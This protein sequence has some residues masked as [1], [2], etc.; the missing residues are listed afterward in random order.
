MKQNVQNSH[1]KTAFLLIFIILFL[2]SF[3]L[4]R[5]SSTIP[6]SNIGTK[7]WFPLPQ[8]KQRPTQTYKNIHD[9]IQKTRKEEI[10]A[11]CRATGVPKPAAN[12]SVQLIFNNKYNISYLDIP[13]IGSTF[14]KQMFSVLEI[15]PSYA[16][17]NFS[18][19]RSIVHKKFLDQG[20]QFYF[21]STLDKMLTIVAVRNPYSRLFATFVDKVYLPNKINL[22][23]NITAY[24]QRHISRDLVNNSR[25]NQGN[26]R[27]LSL[28]FQDFLNYALDPS[29]KNKS[30]FNHYGPCFPQLKYLIC[31][32]NAYSVVKQE[33]FETDIKYALQAVGVDKAEHETYY[34]IIKSLHD[35]RI[36][37]SIPGIIKVTF[38]N[39]KKYVKIWTGRIVATRLWHSFQIQGFISKHIPFPEKY[40][41]SESTYSNVSFVL[42]VFLREMKGRMLSRTETFD[43]RKEIMLNA[44][45]QLSTN[46]IQNIQRTYNDDFK[47][48]GYDKTLT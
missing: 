19:P 4:G 11:Y 8:N 25:A 35:S 31:N 28:T 34:T 26:S 16:K 14:I 17:D 1:S 30:L 36:E 10:H 32:S 22:V 2:L 27:G 37:D 38:D 23:S 18:I 41:E 5:Y 3:I 48:F 15:G 33:T 21:N 20:K 6:V 24:K 9:T 39:A 47:A 7:E 12:D 44:Y 42:N 29:I 43:Q 46:V 40:F 13:K 45:K